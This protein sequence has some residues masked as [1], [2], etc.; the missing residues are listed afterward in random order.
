MKNKIFLKLFAIVVI[1]LFLSTTTNAQ[2]DRTFDFNHDRSGVRIV[3]QTRG[4]VKMQFSLDKMSISSFD[5][6]GEQMQSISISEFYIPNEKGLP[7]VPSISRLIAVP[8][9]AEAVLHIT[10]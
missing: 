2:E 10:S 1:S 6:R 5:Y 8:Q 4:N 7:N 3:E 9:G